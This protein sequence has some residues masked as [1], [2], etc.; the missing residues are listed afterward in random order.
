MPLPHVGPQPKQGPREPGTQAARG[1]WRPA[2]AVSSL[3]E[4]LAPIC[5]GCRP[6]TLGLPPR[7]RLRGPGWHQGQSVCTEPS[8]IC[9]PLCGMV[10]PGEEAK[11]GTNQKRL[12]ICKGAQTGGRRPDAVASTWPPKGP[13][14]LLPGRGLALW[15]AAQA[16]AKSGRGQSG[17]RRLS[18]GVLPSGLTHFPACS[19]R[20]EILTQQQTKNEMLLSPSARLGSNKKNIF[21]FVLF[22]KQQIYKTT[23]GTFFLFFVFLFS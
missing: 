1:P 11:D 10:L 17:G 9:R 4:S 23:V 14:L 18:L 21:C 13:P 16:S 8:R 12:F 7:S 22:L 19:Q 5:S 15:P 20:S 2:S 6:P 3:P